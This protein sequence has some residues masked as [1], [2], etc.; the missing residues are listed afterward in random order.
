MFS[1]GI[2]ADSLARFATIDQALRLLKSWR[3]DQ[4]D[5]LLFGSGVE[6]IVRHGSN[7]LP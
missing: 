6:E 5:V 3:V 2:S 4:D 1:N 7:L